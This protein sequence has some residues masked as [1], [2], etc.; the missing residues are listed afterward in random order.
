VKE[1]ISADAIIELAYRVE[2][3]RE[4]AACGVVRAGGVAKKRPSANGSLFSC[5]INKEHTGAYT[6]IEVGR[7]VA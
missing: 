2:K 5:G 4:C 6:S 7:A 1:R 3:E